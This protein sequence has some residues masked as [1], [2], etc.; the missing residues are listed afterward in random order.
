MINFNG[1][2]S[3]HAIKLNKNS[4]RNPWMS[5]L[6]GIAAAWSR[7]INLNYVQNMSGVVNVAV[8]CKTDLLSSTLVCYFV[9]HISF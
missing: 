3:E 2:K 6:N 9:C 7:R 8:T 4:A 5:E 1:G